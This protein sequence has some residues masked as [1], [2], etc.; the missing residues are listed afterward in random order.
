LAK[1]HRQ[2]SWL[3]HEL[4]QCAWA[5][6]CWK[7]KKVFLEYGKK[8]MLLTVTLILSWLM[9]LSDWCRPIW[10]CQLTSSETDWTLMMCERI[11]LRS[12]FVAAAAYSQLL[13]GLLGKYLLVSELHNAHIVRQAFLTTIFSGWILDGSLSLV[14]QFVHAVLEHDDFLNTYFTR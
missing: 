5:L 6:S 3:P 9:E 10:S 7:M 1:L 2:E 4:W 8:Q 14:W 12:L 13:C 11:L